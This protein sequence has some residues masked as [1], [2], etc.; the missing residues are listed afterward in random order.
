MHFKFTKERKSTVQ[1]ELQIN[2][3]ITQMHEVD[4]EEEGETSFNEEISQTNSSG[5]I[6]GC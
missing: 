2:F 3:I 4:R 6:L 1:K 5:T